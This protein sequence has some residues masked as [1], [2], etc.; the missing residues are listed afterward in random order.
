MC[1][2]GLFSVGTLRRKKRAAGEGTTLQNCYNCNSG[3]LLQTTLLLISAQTLPRVPSVF[4][5]DKPF[6]IK[7]LICAFPALFPGCTF[8][9][10]VQDVSLVQVLQRSQDLMHV[11]QGEVLGQA[12]PFCQQLPQRV[13]RRRKKEKKKTQDKSTDW[14]YQ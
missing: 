2:E 1:L 8:D 11:V 9:V 10:Q 13:W 7:A 5:P 6:L 4:I 14:H 12:T 3:S